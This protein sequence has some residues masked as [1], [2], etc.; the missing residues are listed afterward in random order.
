MKE[1][2]KLECGIKISKD[3]YDKLMTIT[4]K[5]PRKVIDKIMKQ[6]YVTT[7]ELVE[8]GYNHAP[9]AARDVRENGIP[10]DT[11]MVKDP[12]T[13]K[14]MA[15]YTF[16]D[17]EQYQSKNKLLMTNGRNNLTEKLK[18]KLIQENGCRCALYNEP[19][20]ESLLQTDHRIPFEIAGDPDDMMDTSKFMLLS[21]SANRAKDWAC[22]HCTNWT[23]KDIAM[24]KACYYAFPENYTHVAGKEE[25]VLDMAFHKD[26]LEIYNSVVEYAKSNGTSL[27]EAAKSLMKY[28][29]L[30]S[31]KK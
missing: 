23:E 24:C 16:G 2:V 14:R 20:P 15:Q 12:A 30:S 10:L 9:R 3:F 7:E 19:F 25:R 29:S 5:R 8:I 26:D 17:W 1:F 28:A 4:A 31:K 22:E 13:G 27:Q 18:Q 6:G 21:P 11:K